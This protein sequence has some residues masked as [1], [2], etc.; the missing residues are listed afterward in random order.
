MGATHYSLTLPPKESGAFFKSPQVVPRKIGAVIPVY[1]DWSGLKTTL[2]SLQELSPCPGAITVV[3][4][5]VD[6]HIPA[7]LNNYPVE[8]I[9]YDG[10]HGPAY[11]RNQVC[12]RHFADYDWIYFTDCGCEHVRNIIAHFVN[13]RDKRDHSVVA[14]CGSTSGKGSGKINRYMTEMNIL[15]PPFESHLDLYGEKFHKQ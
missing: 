2:D 9:N 1:N 12:V 4:V 10:N 13:A 14:V 3:N 5:N 11:A 6:N 8:I 7:W 15:N